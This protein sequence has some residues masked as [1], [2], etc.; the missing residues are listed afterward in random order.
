M[1]KLR[2]MGVEGSVYLS[3]CTLCVPHVCAFMETESRLASVISCS[4][5]TKGNGSHFLLELELS[6]LCAQRRQAMDMLSPC[7]RL[8]QLPDLPLPA[9]VLS[10]ACSLLLGPRLQLTYSHR[11]RA[12]HLLSHTSEVL[13][14]TLPWRSREITCY[15]DKNQ[16]ILVCVCVTRAGCVPRSHRACSLFMGLL[17]L[18]SLPQLQQTTQNTEQQWKHSSSV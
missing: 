7:F 8:V 13:G 5:K 18:L 6:E 15:S 11:R 3:R 4:H 2:E 16:Q 17:S 12:R 9:S 10:R 14:F 1:W